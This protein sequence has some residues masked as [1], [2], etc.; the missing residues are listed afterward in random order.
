MTAYTFERKVPIEV[1][2]FTVNKMHRIFGTDSF[3]FTWQNKV[4]E[5]EWLHFKVEVI[6]TPPV[7][8]GLSIQFMHFK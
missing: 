4:F 5:A 1:P 7:G 3:S 8:R 6:G 2:Q